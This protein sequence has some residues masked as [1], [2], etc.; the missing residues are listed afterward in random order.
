MSLID[1][2]DDD[3]DLNEKGNLTMTSIRELAMDS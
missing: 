3:M 1:S 2:T